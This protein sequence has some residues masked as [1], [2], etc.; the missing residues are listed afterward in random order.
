MECL[1]PSDPDALAG[2]KLV[3]LEDIRCHDNICFGISAFANLKGFFIRSEWDILP[4]P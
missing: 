3:S 4:K 2:F 1:Q